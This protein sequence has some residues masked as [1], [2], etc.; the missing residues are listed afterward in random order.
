[1]ADLAELARVYDKVLFAGG[2]IL[3]DEDY[4]LEDLNFNTLVAELSSLFIA[5]KNRASFTE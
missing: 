2:A 3:S 1:M 5:N 4:A